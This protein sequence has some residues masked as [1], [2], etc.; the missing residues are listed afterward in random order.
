[1]VSTVASRCSSILRP[2]LTS[3]VRT[4]FHSPTSSGMASIS[5]GTPPDCRGLNPGGSRR[6]PLPCMV[7]FVEVFFLLV[8]FRLVFRSLSS[9]VIAL[10][11]VGCRMDRHRPDFEHVHALFKFVG[12]KSA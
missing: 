12:H 7:V 10:S 9:E 5:Q 11:P 4:P 8:F 6:V 3:I 1:S 2:R